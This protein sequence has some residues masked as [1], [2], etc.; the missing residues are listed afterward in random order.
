VLPYPALLRID[1]KYDAGGIAGSTY[2]VWGLGDPIVFKGNTL[3][4]NWGHNRLQVYAGLN[5]QSLYQLVKTHHAFNPFQARYSYRILKPSLQK[6]WSDAD[7]MFTMNRD[8]FGRGFFGIKDE[9]RIYQGRE[10]DGKMVYYCVGT[11]RGWRMRCWHSKEEYESG[12]S[13]LTIS[14]LPGPKYAPC[15]VLSQVANVGAF[16][17]G[18]P[19]QYYLF[20]NAGEDTAL[21]LSFSIL[22]DSTE[23]QM[24]EAADEA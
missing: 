19:D 17:Q 15:A 22:Y 5:P 13:S 20:T 2:Y 16:V 21:L 11:W 7:I 4:R 18:V 8:I 14:G 9:W 24:E 10:R 23:D 3:S 6:H 12:R 1:E